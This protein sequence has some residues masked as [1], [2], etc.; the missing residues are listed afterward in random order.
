MK[1]LMTLVASALLTVS[2]YAQTTPTLEGTWLTQSGEAKIKITKTGEIY[3]GAIVWLKTPLNE[4]GKAKV[5]HKNPDVKLRSRPVMGLNLISG[6]KKAGEKKYDNGK[7][8]D[9][10]EGKLYSCTI[11]MRDDKA[12]DVRG[13]VGISLLGKTQVWYRVADIK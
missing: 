8:Y 9:P 13:Y 5:D 11:N 6:F 7:I 12:I 2:A 3:N 10:K 1:K 4:E